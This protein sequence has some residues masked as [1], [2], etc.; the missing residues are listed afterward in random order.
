LEQ[1]TSKKTETAYWVY[2][3]VFFISSIKTRANLSG[4]RKTV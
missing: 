2:F 4:H 3:A 1:N